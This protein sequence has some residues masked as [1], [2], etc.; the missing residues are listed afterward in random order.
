MTTDAAAGITLD[1]GLDPGLAALL[2]AIAGA[3]LPALGEGTPESA[4]T[5]FRSMTCDI[6]PAELV[7]PV[8]G[9]ENG[10]LA[11]PAGP[12]AFRTYRPERGPDVVAGTAV[13]TILFVHGGG[14]VIGDLDTHDNEARRLCR[15]TGAVVVSIDYR[16]A[17]EAAFPA[18]VEDAWAA[19]LWVAAHAGELGGDPAALAVCGDSAG[20]NLAA[21]VARRARD[22]GGPALVAQLLIYPGVDLADGDVATYPSRLQNAE[23]Y[24]LGLEDMIWFAGHY[25]GDWTAAG[26]DLTDPDLSPLHAA[27][28]SGLPH[29]A[30]VVAEFDPLRDEGIA[31][32]KALEA[33]GTPVTL[34]H[35][36]GMIH[37]YFDLAPLSPGVEAAVARTTALFSDALR[38]A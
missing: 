18:P 22:A 26:R 37:G 33:A 21:V 30:I 27:D 10:E 23:G 31:Y 11:G 20:G 4:R 38:G 19:L 14:W 1:P 25:T 24:L 29:A 3:N 35:L 28:L 9:V 15:D 12:I 36:D 5:A 6:R 2:A 16:R 8:G 17:P 7:V 34:L 32:A 13:P